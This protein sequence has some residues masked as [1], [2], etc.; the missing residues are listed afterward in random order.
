MAGVP[1][2][3]QTYE[4]KMA[5]HVPGRA[6]IVGAYYQPWADAVAKATN[7]RVTIKMYAEETLVK[8]ADQYDA[9]V[10]GLADLSSVTADATPGR[11]PNAEFYG[12]PQLFPSAEVGAR[13]Y[14]DVLQK[15]SV[16]TEL[17]DVM[18]LGTPTIAPAQYFGNKEAKVPADM[19]GQ[20]VRS[21]GQIEAWL[22]E[23][24]G[25]TPVEISTGELST[26]MERGMADSCFLSYSF[27][28]ITGIK[29][30]TKYR[31]EI[32]EFYRSFMLIMNKEVWDSMPTVLQDQMMS[33]SGPEAS[34]IYSAAN[35]ALAA[36]DKAAI[37]GS[38]KG[39][40]NPPIYVPTPEE[41]QLWID[42]SK[43]VWDKW[44]QE[45]G[46]DAQAVVD[47]AV[48]LTAKYA[49]MPPIEVTT[50]T[51]V[52]GTT[53]IFFEDLGGG[54]V[55]VTISPEAGQKFDVS[56]EGPFGAKV[57]A[58]DKDGK[59]L[60]PLEIPESAAGVLDYA[61]VAGIAKIV[62]TDVAHGGATYEYLVP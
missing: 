8:E 40:G 49:A 42:A 13:V 11:F 17:K 3:G 45:T 47:M 39:A 46:G 34:A 25:A 18:L 56:T 44:V 53:G 48:E 14:W 41:M 24:L 54:K 6:S 36:E 38:D 19:K 29:D 58:F 37:E 60:G 26:S 62:A 22:I 10:S 21:G 31:T 50:T 4:L 43:P 33:V 30:V 5:F 59:S 55:K 61:K 12:L 2:T 27:G 32:N 1:D 20:R 15:Y 16:P 57:E 7:N 9:V 28:L 35:E 52:A 23:E 51:A